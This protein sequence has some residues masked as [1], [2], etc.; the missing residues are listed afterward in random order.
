MYISCKNQRYRCIPY[1][2]N[3]EQKIL[4]SYWARIFWPI[5]S[6]AEFF[7]GLRRKT[8]HCKLFHFRLF[9]AK[10]NDKLFGSILQPFGLL[11]G[12]QT[13]IF[14]ERPLGSLFF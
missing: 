14:Q 8:E 6:E 1:T 9:P 11:Q 2:D 7:Q 12:G 13:R 10:S 5:I 4:Q 3:D